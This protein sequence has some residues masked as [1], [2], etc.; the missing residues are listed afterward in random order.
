MRLGLAAR[1]QTGQVKLHFQSFDHLAAPLHG[2]TAG[3]RHARRNHPPNRPGCPVL[4][5]SDIACSH[6][7]LL[8]DGPMLYF[9]VGP[10]SAKDLQELLQVLSKPLA[11]SRARCVQS[12]LSSCQRRR[13]RGCFGPPS[14][15]AARGGARTGSFGLW[16][17]TGLAW[18]ARWSLVHGVAGRTSV[19]WGMHFLY[20]ICICGYWR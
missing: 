9:S 12:Q 4:M 6:R 11:P 14:T 19:I 7:S 8:S 20:V 15:M 17:S 13:P 10:T 2:H 5:L 3:H 1:L 18:H 16:S